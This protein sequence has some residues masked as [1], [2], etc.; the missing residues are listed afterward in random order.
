MNILIAGA[1]MVGFRLAKALSSKHSVILVDK[2]ESALEK[3]QENIDVLTVPGNVEDPNSYK[4]IE[5]KN[6]DIFIAVTD[7]DET[8]LVSSIIVSEKINVKQKI[9]RLRKKFL[10]KVV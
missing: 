10:P 2:N 9:I 7:T 5:D 1:G 8:N 4:A 6:I 3:I